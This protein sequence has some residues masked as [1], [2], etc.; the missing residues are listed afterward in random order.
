MQWHLS[1]WQL[2]VGHDG[3]IGITG[4]N[5]QTLPIGASPNTVQ[6]IR[7]YLGAVSGALIL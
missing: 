2:E 1:C 3:R 4:M 5:E 7:Q 6:P